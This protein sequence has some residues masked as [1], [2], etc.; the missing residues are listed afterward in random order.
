MTDISPD[1]LLDQQQHIRYKYF[2][3]GAVI[4]FMIYFFLQLV[5]NWELLLFSYFLIVLGLAPSL[6]AYMDSAH[7]F[8]YTQTPYI[9]SPQSGIG[10]YL[11]QEKCWRILVP[12]YLQRSSST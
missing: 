8:R 11:V 7:L 4:F 1:Y 2:L 3:A 10:R 5:F 12:Y 6:L 9:I